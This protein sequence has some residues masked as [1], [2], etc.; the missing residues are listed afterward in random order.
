MYRFDHPEPASN[1]DLGACHGVEIP[2]VFDTAGGADLEPRLGSQPSQATANRIHQ[3]WV[4]FI[5][6]GAPG[7][8]PYDPETR[9]TGLLTDVVTA[10]DDPAGHERAAWDGI[11]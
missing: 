3:V 9:T 8:A 4:D 2:F 5:T 7:W 6:R 10:A 1:H 11:R